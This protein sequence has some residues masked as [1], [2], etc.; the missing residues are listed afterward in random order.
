MFAVGF[1]LEPLTYDQAKQLGPEVL[2]HCF[3]SKR[4]IQDGLT[5]VTVKLELEE[6]IFVV[7]MAEDVDEHCR[8]RHVRVPQVTITKRDSSDDGA[9]TKSKKV[10]PQQPTLRAT[11]HCLIDPAEKVH[12]EF[13][14]GFFAKDMF[15]SF[16]DEQENLFT[17]LH[18]DDEDADEQPDLPDTEADG[19]VLDEQVSNARINKETRRRRQKTDTTPRLAKP[20]V[21]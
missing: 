7:R 8:L 2:N 9:S 21:H 16:L 18:G 12:R 20:E 3:T 4:S 13:L 14:A 19:D 1:V 11:F 15:F 10:G 6:Q 5:S 17:G